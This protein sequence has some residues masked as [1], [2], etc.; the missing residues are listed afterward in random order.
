MTREVVL[1]SCMIEFARL[2][3]CTW[4]DSHKKTLRRMLGAIQ[5]LR[6][7]MGVGGGHTFTPYCLNSLG[8]L[9]VFPKRMAVGVKPKD[10]FYGSAQISFTKVCVP[11][12]LVLQSGEGFPSC[13]EKSVT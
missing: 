1:R 6:N 7:A 9:L 2:A 3:Q 8:M 5:V 11:P 10:D 12:L 13:R 4:K